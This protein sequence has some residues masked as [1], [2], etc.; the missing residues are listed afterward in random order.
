MLVKICGIQTKE[1]A[2]VAI[3]SGADFIGFVFADSKRKMEP[4]QAARIVK[5]I[6]NSVQKVGVFVNESVEK[7]IDIAEQ[8]GLDVIQLHGDE[9]PA[10]AEK[11]PYKVIKAFAVDA[12]CLSEIQTYPCDYYL[13]DSPKGKY[14]GGNG[15]TFDWDL[16]NHLPLDSS[17]VILAGG[18]SAENVQTAIRQAKPAGVDVSSGVETNR[19]KDLNKITQFIKQAKATGKDEFNGNIHH[20]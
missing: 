18:L 7:M 6:P 1:A 11:L 13:L 20:A 12:N 8:V 2:E 16:L 17:K 5:N 4:T 9:S 10:I 15:K 19:K 3:S 14:R